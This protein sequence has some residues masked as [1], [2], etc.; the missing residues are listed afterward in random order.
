M[1]EK[2]LTNRLTET[3]R[4]FQTSTPGVLGAAVISSDGF[5]IASELPTSVEEC[6]VAAMA[7]AMLALGK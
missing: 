7:A 6:R 2:D 5:A 1:A 3:L 4:A